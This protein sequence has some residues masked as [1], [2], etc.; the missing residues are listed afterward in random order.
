MIQILRDIEVHGS[1]VLNRARGQKQETH[2]KIEI[3]RIFFVGCVCT[4][5]CQ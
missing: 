1:V 3:Y 4:D 5:V 2:Q